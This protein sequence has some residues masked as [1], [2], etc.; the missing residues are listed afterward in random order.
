MTRYLILEV[1]RDGQPR[2][3]YS[4][5]LRCRDRM[6]VRIGVGSIYR[7]LAR[8]ATLGWVEPT[9]NPAG[10]D[11]RRRP[12]GITA[13]GRV[14]LDAWLAGPVPGA[15]PQYVDALVL[16][17]FL[18]AHA[19]PHLPP[20]VVARWREELDI[21]RGMLDGERERLAGIAKREGTSSSEGTF[22]ANR[23]RHLE[24]DIDFLDELARHGSYPTPRAAG[25]V[26]PPPRG[27]LWDGQAP[28]RA[29][30]RARRDDHRHHAV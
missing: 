3:G 8:L 16:H 1:L 19:A 23:I 29:M 26:P 2:H 4:V 9:D 5:M 11:A 15:V 13:A 18:V 17:A 7:E 6:G 12:F 25:D 30:R 22:L 21:R 14:A 10:D 27:V 28:A 20:D 24:V